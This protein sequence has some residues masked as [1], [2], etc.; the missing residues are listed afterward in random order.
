MTKK[1]LYFMTNDNVKHYCLIEGVANRKF[2]TF[3][4]NWQNNVDGFLL[5]GLE[6]CR[7]VVVLL[8]FSSICIGVFKTATC[9][10]CHHVG[11]LNL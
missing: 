11:M 6:Y 10:S 4:W 2:Q 5:A 9:S 8:G 3:I 1:Q 7:G